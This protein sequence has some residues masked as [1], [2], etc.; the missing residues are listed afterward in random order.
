MT[1]RRVAIGALVFVAGIAAGLLGATA[2]SIVWAAAVAVLGWALARFL[3]WR[4]EWRRMA[5]TPA[6]LPVRERDA[7]I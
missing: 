3:H 2:E 7:A 6:P 1:M 5:G 4:G